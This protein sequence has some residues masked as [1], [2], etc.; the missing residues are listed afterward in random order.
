MG[1]IVAAETT[2]AVALILS[3]TLFLF[4]LNIPF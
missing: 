4:N 1:K 3:H 2:S